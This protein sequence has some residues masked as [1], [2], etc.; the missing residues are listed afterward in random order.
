MKTNETAR[1]HSGEILP[2]NTTDASR[3]LVGPNGEQPAYLVEGMNC[4]Q[5][6]KPAFRLQLIPFCLEH[7]QDTLR[8]A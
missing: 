5:C 7:N 4:A 6:G 8:K 3:S 1:V 2:V